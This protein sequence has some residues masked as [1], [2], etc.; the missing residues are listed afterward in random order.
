MFYAPALQ[1]CTVRVKIPDVNRSKCD[2]QSIIAIVLEKTTDGFYRLGTKYNIL[3]QLY[4]R[5]QFNLCT[6]PALGED[7]WVIC[8]G[9][10]AC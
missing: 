4:T 2:P 9:P 1:E 5:S 8:P 10:R 6:V 3:K 7:K